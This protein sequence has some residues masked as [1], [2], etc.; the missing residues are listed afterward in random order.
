MQLRACSA[1]FVVGETV[2]HGP[3]AFR[4]CKQAATPAKSTV[5]CG[6]AENSTPNK[7]NKNAGV[8]KWGNEDPKLDGKC[9]VEAA[10]TVG[11]IKDALATSASAVAANEKKEA[12]L[13]STRAGAFS[14]IQK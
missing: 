12:A 9:A 10:N 2:G 13:R 5:S 8:C 11:D 7:C 6:S 1:H 4:C 14:Q 3:E